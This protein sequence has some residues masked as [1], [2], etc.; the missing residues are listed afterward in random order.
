MIEDENLS[1]GSQ[2][3][4]DLGAGTSIEERI[5]KELGSF[6]S[7]IEIGAEERPP[8]NELPGISL[9]PGIELGLD[10]MA[11]LMSEEPSELIA[12][13]GAQDTGKTLYLVALYLICACGQAQDFGYEFAGSLTLPGFEDRARASRRWQ[14][15]K[16]P[17]Q[18]SAHTRV[19]DSRGPG[20]M[21]LDLL[22]IETSSLRR[23]LL[24]DL[25]GE[26]TSQLIDSAHVSERLSFLGRADVIC[27]MIEG[28]S[29]VGPA[30]HSEVEKQRMLIDRVTAITAPTGRKMAII[31]TKGDIINLEQPP[32]LQ[33]IAEYAKAAGFE[34]TAMT[35]ASVSSQKEI[36][37]G[38]GIFESLMW[39][40]S[41]AERVISGKSSEA[42]RPG[43]FFGWSPISKG[44]GCFD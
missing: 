32:A 8:V 31:A 28:A 39:M 24:S 26:W 18:M 17:T 2:S 23:L 34:T 41:P 13:L 21:H 29:L 40:L 16:V 12:I 9:Y 30:R 15:D 22:H 10:D 44:S 42:R 11:V 20:F 5:A 37:S 35:I 36:D 6:G 1:Q 33:E 27:L 7:E 19:G 3:G 4:G 38:A 14:M 43:R 25:P